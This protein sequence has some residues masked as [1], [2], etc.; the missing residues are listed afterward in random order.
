M[1]W[2]AERMRLGRKQEA[3]PIAEETGRL[4]MTRGGDWVSV[5]ERG[6]VETLC[7]AATCGNTALCI[8]SLWALLVFTVA[9][10]YS[11]CIQARFFAGPDTAAQ[12]A[13]LLRMIN[14]TQCV[15][16]VSPLFYDR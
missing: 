12:E 1:R 6:A 14:T 10:L 8:A 3:P 16:L 9:I 11:D 13:G 5:P 7:E 2:L 15:H 4:M